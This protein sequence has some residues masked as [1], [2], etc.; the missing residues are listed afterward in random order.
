MGGGVI[1]VFVPPPYL[2]PLLFGN[3]QVRY[4]E[5][6]NGR[7]RLR[8]PML[9]IPLETSFHHVAKDPHISLY[10]API[11]AIILSTRLQVSGEIHSW[12]MRSI[13]RGLVTPPRSLENRQSL[14]LAFRGG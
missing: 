5:V 10:P 12:Q 6:L 8:C 4:E 11:A 13:C 2:D 7:S 14:V 1:R 9:A 3:S